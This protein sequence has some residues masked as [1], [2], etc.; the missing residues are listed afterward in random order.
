MTEPRLHFTLA[1]TLHS[2][3][4]NTGIQ[5]YWANVQSAVEISQS[6]VVAKRKISMMKKE[7][8]ALQIVRSLV[9]EKLP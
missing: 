4:R 6:N 2:I 1:T 5:T 9:F 7:R 8:Q 3:P